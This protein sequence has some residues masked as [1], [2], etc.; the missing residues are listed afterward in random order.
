MMKKLSCLFLVSLFFT[1]VFSQGD[2]LLAKNR[3]ELNIGTFNAFNLSSISDIGIGFKKHKKNGAFRFMLNFSVSNDNN[4]ESGT[5]T[6]TTGYSNLFFIS[7]RVGYEFQED[8]K[9]MKFFYGLDLKGDLRKFSRETVN[10]TSAYKYMS[11]YRSNAFGLVPFIGF[12]YR[13]NERF[14]ISTE[15][16]IDIMYSKGLNRIETSRNN[17]VEDSSSQSDNKFYA[18]LSPLGLFTFNFHF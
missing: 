14:S 18:N 3:N 2:S 16:N 12:K 5:N 7:P 9:K 17:L 4:F 11:A 15:T 1:D 10:S 8:F 13:F 6:N